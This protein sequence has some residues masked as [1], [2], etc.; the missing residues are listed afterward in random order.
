[1]WRHSVRQ[2]CG[3]EWWQ[4]IDVVRQRLPYTISYLTCAQW[5]PAILEVCIGLAVRDTDKDPTTQRV[6]ERGSCLS[7]LKGVAAN[8]ALVLDKQRLVLKE[9]HSQ[10]VVGDICQRERPHR[11]EATVEAGGN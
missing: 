4:R 7:D 10:V 11:C 5:L 6:R 3:S 1:M 9:H 2:D 8:A